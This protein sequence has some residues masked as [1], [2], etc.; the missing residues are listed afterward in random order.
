MKMNEKNYELW[1]D[2]TFKT[3]SYKKN[4]DLIYEHENFITEHEGIISKVQ[5]MKKKPPIQVGEYQF[6]TWNLGFAREFN[7]NPLKQLKNYEFEN[8]YEELLSLIQNGT[9]SLNEKNKL[10]LLHTLIIHPDYRKMGVTEE[11]IEYLYR[12]FVYGNNNLL[13]AL[14]KPIQN[15][16]IDYDY[17]WDKKKM[18]IKETIGKNAP[19]KEVTANEYYKLDDLIKESDVEIN[20]YKLFS[21]AA[22]CGFKRIDESH[23][24]AL[25]PKKIIDR[26]KEKR[27][28]MKTFDNMDDIDELF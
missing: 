14:V 16:P 11:F 5:M 13:I 9:L 3:T 27:S 26:I 21:V 20:E 6:S 24:F 19:Y 18:R 2:L 17:F 1:N 28:F 22:R 10:I 4:F 8:T 7:I 25:D 15:N 23:L 12:G